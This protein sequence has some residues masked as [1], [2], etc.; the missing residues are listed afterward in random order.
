MLSPDLLIIGL[1]VSAGMAIAAAGAAIWHSRAGQAVEA[2]A[3]TAAFTAAEKSVEW[4][5][6]K[7]SHVKAI[8]AEQAKMARK[9]Q[10]KAQLLQKLQSS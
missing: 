7:S 3:E 2:D 8:A 1:S 6:D 4:L 9:D 10:L 5:S